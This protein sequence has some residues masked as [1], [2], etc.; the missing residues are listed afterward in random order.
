MAEHFKISP[1]AGIIAIAALA[2][3]GLVAWRVSVAVADLSSDDCIVETVTENGVEVSR[4]QH[5]T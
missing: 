1:G 4:T 3:L 2:A 5:C